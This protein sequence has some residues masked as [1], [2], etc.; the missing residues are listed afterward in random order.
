M[1]LAENIVVEQNG[2]ISVIR[3]GTLI[4]EEHVVDEHSAYNVIRSAK[5]L[6]NN[7]EIKDGEIEGAQTAVDDYNYHFSSIAYGNILL[8]SSVLLNGK[9]PEDATTIIKDDMINLKHELID[10]VVDLYLPEEIK[11]YSPNYDNEKIEIDD[12][13]ID[14]DLL[15]LMTR[16]YIEREQ[17]GEE[18]FYRGSRHDY[19]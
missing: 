18:P 9:S 1:K 11:D 8:Q 7:V 19:R 2:I 3:S 13:S 12:Y 4:K 15:R 5:V 10:E 14:G 17:V 6:E 16:V